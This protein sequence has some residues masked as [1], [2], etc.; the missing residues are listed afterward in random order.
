MTQKIIIS[1]FPFI[2]KAGRG[3]LGERE[4]IVCFRCKYKKNHTWACTINVILQLDYKNNTCKYFEKSKIKDQDSFFVI[5]TSNKVKFLI[6]HIF[7]HI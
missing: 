7:S 2:E 4:R 5:A 1:K 6:T 3:K